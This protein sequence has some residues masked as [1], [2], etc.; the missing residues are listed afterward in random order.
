MFIYN[1]FRVLVIQCEKT[2]H[3]VLAGYGA[4]TGGVD[5]LL[6]T[7]EKKRKGAYAGSSKLQR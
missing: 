6:T 1:G 2:I 5:L 3:V 7:Q 4:D